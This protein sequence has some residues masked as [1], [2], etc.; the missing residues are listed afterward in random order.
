M[1]DCTANLVNHRQPRQV[2]SCCHVTCSN[3]T[4]LSST[5]AYFKPSNIRNFFC[6]A[7]NHFT[8]HAGLYLLILPVR[9]T[10]VSRLRVLH[11]APSTTAKCQHLRLI[12]FGKTHQLHGTCALRLTSTESQRS[13]PTRC[14]CSFIGCK[15]Y[16][17]RD[18][19]TWQVGAREEPVLSKL[20]RNQLNLGAMD[21]SEGSVRHWGRAHQ[22]AD[23][24]SRR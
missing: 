8:I 5:T 1:P 23:F 17:V 12:R 7:Y 2:A 4:W 21:W 15:A 14:S 3:P 19:R 13:S 10:A 6:S 20:V 16:I 11:A 24:Y 9:V 18:T 22:Q